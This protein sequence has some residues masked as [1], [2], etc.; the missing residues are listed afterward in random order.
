MPAALGF[1]ASWA[2]PMSSLSG[3]RVPFRPPPFVFGVVWPILYGMLGYSSYLSARDPVRLSIHV[4]LSLMLAAWVVLDSCMGRVK[5]GVWLL[6]ASVLVCCYAI[7]ADEGRQ[8]A[9]LLLPLAAW[10]SFA[11][12]M[13]AFRTSGEYSDPAPA[14][15]S[16][17]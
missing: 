13:S 1:G 10:L 11:T 12:L 14:S 4:A 17:F 15:G 7:A 16:K 8:T 2:C 5:E 3:S 6:L 9:M